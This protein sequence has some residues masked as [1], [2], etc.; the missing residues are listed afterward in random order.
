MKPINSLRSLA[1]I[2]IALDA[3]TIIDISDV[4]GSIIYANEKF[5]ETSKFSQE[6]ILAENHRILN[7][8]YHPKEY[9][10]SLW[11]TIQAGEIWKGEIKNKAK[12]GTYYWTD[13]TI[14]PFLNEEGTPYQYV[15]IR[16]DITKRKQTEDTLKSTLM[17]L[18]TSNKELSDIKHALDESSIVAMTDNKGIITYVN[19]TF[20]AISKYEREEL[21]GQ[22][23]RILNSSYHAKGFFKN[24]WST[25]GQGRVWKGEI[26]NKAKDGS[27]Y[28]VYTTIVPFLNDQGRPYK[29]V[30]IRNDITEQKKAED[31]LLRSE[32]L[33]AIGELAAG[34][35]H[36][37]RNP[38]TTLKGFTAFLIEA[39]TD[40]KKQLYLK[41]LLEEV[42]RINFI[43]GEFMVLAKPQAIELK[44]KPLIPIIER[45]RTFL[46]SEMNLHNVSIILDVCDESIEVECEENQMKQ[47]F[48][49]ILK[50]AIEAMP[51]GGNVHISV[52]VKKSIVEVT[53][54]D[55]GTGIP[56]EIIEKIGDPFFSTKESGNGLGMMVC[57]TIIKNHHG[58]IV[59][60]SKENEGTIIRISLP[61]TE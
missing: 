31:L 30:A 43:V 25:I 5:C 10:T 11:R 28:W 45:V 37:I 7:A 33:S 23:H 61:Y 26:K 6:E 49:N 46:V 53:I 59:I 13:T 9:F 44:M 27:Y 15:T 18:D 42:E 41:L 57:Y 3:T 12:D 14:V 29:Y 4:Q 52:L 2:I 39:E 22:D 21:I 19:D 1:D 48:L 35:A 58:S 32:K 50:N 38:L 47:V 36:E 16:A 20:C 56:K 8:N 51:N 34:V 24:L 40:H 54:K 17:K 55:E 60:D